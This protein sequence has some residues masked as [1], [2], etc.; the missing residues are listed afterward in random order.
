MSYYI[1]FLYSP[2]SSKRF[3]NQRKSAI[4]GIKLT[5]QAVKKPSFTPLLYPQL[6]RSR[7]HIGPSFIWYCHYVTHCLTSSHTHHHADHKWNQPYNPH[8]YTE[9]VKCMKRL[10]IFPCQ[11]NRCPYRMDKHQEDRDHACY[12]VDTHHR[13]LTLIADLR[14]HSGSDCVHCK[15]KPEKYQM[16]WF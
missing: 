11:N 14:H 13:A 6:N 2:T 1:A 12:P 4:N 10:L 8:Y 5:I 16:D 7:I 3:L 9:P 15:T